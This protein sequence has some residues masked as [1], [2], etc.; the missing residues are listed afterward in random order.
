[1]NEAMLLPCPGFGLYPG[2]CVA[3]PGEQDPVS[4]SDQGTWAAVHL[5][6]AS[7]NVIGA[8]GCAGSPA[9]RRPL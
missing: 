9:P 7:V 2:H 1:M 3:D 5:G 4:E 8:S 6:C